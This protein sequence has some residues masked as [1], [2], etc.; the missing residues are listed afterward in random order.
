MDRQQQKTRNAIFSAFNGLLS[1]KR[2]DKITVQEII[3]KANVGRTTFYAHFS[4]KD[5]LLREMCTTLFNHVFSDVLEVEKTHDFSMS[6]DRTDTMITHMLY[7]LRDNKKNILGVMSCES[8]ELFL[9]FFKQYLNS[10]LAKKMMP[11]ACLHL[12]ED[13]IINHISGSFINMVQWWIKGRMKQS[14]EDLAEYF[15]AVINPIF[16]EKENFR[17]DKEYK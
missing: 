17:V 11:V 13:F 6:L 5:D 10:V 4:T 3:D 16:S 8:G 1:K 2:Y 7:H 15:K 12:P 14:P 9:Q